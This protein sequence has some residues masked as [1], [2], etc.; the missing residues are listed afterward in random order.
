MAGYVLHLREEENI[1]LSAGVLR[2]LIDGG[3]GDAALLY[4]AILRAHGSAS[5]EKLAGELHWES[6]RVRAAEQAL[7]SMGLVGAPQEAPE[8]QRDDPPPQSRP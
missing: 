4:L 2:R 6:A 3:N 8:P 1:T 5:P 7:F